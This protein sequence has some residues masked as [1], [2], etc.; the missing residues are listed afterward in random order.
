MSANAQTLRQLSIKTGVVRR[1][2]KEEQVY[3]DEAAQQEK[4]LT[5][6]KESDAEG[7]DIRNASLEEA[8]TALEDLVTALASEPEVSTSTEYKAAK[9][10]LDTVNEAWKAESK[11]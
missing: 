8:L 4:V 5:K 2:F 1:L 7:A 9:D 10:Q 11:A 3:K 6:L